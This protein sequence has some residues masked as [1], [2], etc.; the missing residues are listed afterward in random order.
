MELE[1]NNGGKLQVKDLQSQESKVVMV[2]YFVYMGTPYH[3]I[4]KSL[5]LIL[6]NTTSIKE[7]ERMALKDDEEYKALYPRDL[8]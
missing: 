6:R 1:A 8:A 3:I 4:L 7:H 2:L 5:N